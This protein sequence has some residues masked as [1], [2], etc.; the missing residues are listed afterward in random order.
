MR[1]YLA[2]DREWV[3]GKGY[4]K[5]LAMSENDLGIKGGLIQEVTFTEGGT[6]AAHYHKIQTEVFYAL[7][8]VKFEINGKKVMMEPGDIMVC[9]PGEIHSNPYLSQDSR[10]L[11]LK[12]NYQEDDIFWL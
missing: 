12:I 7:D 8:R 3:P 10:I 11:V 9:E 5:R 2:S 1:I 4:K 6:V